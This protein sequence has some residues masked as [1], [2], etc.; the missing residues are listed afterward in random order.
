MDLVSSAFS[1]VMHHHRQP[2]ADKKYE[3][4]SRW[5]FDEQRVISPINNSKYR[6]HQELR[7]Y[8]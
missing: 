4:S 5:H 7:A 1:Q 3:N 8:C 2:A 6:H